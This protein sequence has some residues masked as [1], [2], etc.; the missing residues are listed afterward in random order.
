MKNILLLVHDDGG[1]EARLQAALDLTRALDG[2]LT[3]LDV[4]QFPVLGGDYFTVAGQALLLEDERT[5]E[6]ANRDRL[7]ERLAREDVAW[8]LNEAQGDI[9]DCVTRAAALADL[10]V[11]NRRFERLSAVNMMEIATSVVM[12]TGKAIVA[13]DDDAQGFDA[14]GPALVAWDGS[15]SATAAMRAAVPI[16]QLSGRV[17]LFEVADGSPA[18]SVED[19]A[20]YLS[21]HDVHANIR[22]VQM[23]GSPAEMI[24]EACSLLGASYCVMGAFGHSPL[25]EAILG[26]VTRHM[27][28]SSTIPLVLAH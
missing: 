1:Q 28:A 20:A 27:L 9:A 19:A 22:R 23:A 10:I 8:T 13:V 21:R 14:S 25:R 15:A 26:G 6:A 5:R 12:T 11:L 4:V 3:C 7:K 17:E 16:L 18:A 2:H 24:G